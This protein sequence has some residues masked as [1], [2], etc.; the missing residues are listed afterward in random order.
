MKFSILSI[1]L[2]F[3]Y[4]NGIMSIT[5]ST[6]A[7]LLPS[8]RRLTQKTILRDIFEDVDDRLPFPDY[9]DGNCSDV[10]SVM[11]VNLGYYQ[12]WA[13]WRDDSCYPVRAADIDVIGNGYTHLAYTFAS[14]NATFHLE[15][16]ASNYDGEMPLY[17]EFNAL[18]ETYPGLRTLI[19]VGGWTFSV[20]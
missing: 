13:K 15:P 17:E 20:L 2:V 11:S 6:E 5:E 14:I 7:Q 3:I 9:A 10:D 8:A 19:A 1:W 4:T 16:W 18:K 12:S